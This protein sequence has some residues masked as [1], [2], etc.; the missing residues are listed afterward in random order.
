ML[1]FFA[2]ILFLLGFAFIFRKQVREEFSLFEDNECPNLLIQKDGK[3]IVRNTNAPE[4]EGVNPIIFNHLDEY[5]EYVDWLRSKGK[6]CPILK[7]RAI[8]SAQG[9]TELR[10]VDE[11]N[12]PSLGPRTDFERELNDSGNA[13]GLYQGYDQ[14]NQYIGVYTPLDSK[15]SEKESLP[16]SDNAMDG[17]WGG[18]YYSR[19]QIDAGVYGKD[20]LVRK[21][22]R[23]TKPSAEVVESNN[24][25][26]MIE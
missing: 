26:E 22:R 12:H 7:L 4:K 20:K 3:Y 16:K 10:V 5:E 8:D 1:G 11:I 2:I 13:K 19:S 23:I 14:M 18:V 21:K 6:T 9:K 15:F 25:G 24:S 17:N